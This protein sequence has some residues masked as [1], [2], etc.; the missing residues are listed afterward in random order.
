MTIGDLNLG[1]Y[2][3]AL[4]KELSWEQRLK[5]ASRLGFTFVELSIDETDHRLARLDWSAEQ[6][7]QFRE[8]VLASG[9]TVPTMCF[10]GHRRFPF[11]SH[12]PD[13][14]IKARDLMIKALRFAADTGIRTIQLAGYDVYYEES[15]AQTRQWFKEGL[16]YAVTNAA[17]AQIMIA[18]EI[19]DTPFINSVT[20]FL[21]YKEEL[22]TPWFSVYP[23]IG[24]LSAWGN[25]IEKELEKGIEYA[26]AI[27]LKDTLQV[28]D[29][30]EGKFKEV[31]FGT[32][33]VDFP[34]FFA[35]LKRLSYSG[36]FLIEMW[37]ETSKDPEGDIAHARSWIIEQ[38]RSGGYID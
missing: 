15:D 4:P 28:T 12:D 9:L 23:D 8:I 1:I 26:A 13:I 10:S 25:P 22:K 3:K 27:H 37:T 30:F 21:R 6:R 33:C 16:A 36:T 29:E 18:V 31:P 14:R 5:T 24:N 32:G 7:R 38:M 19:M 2:E 35:L 11:G 20:E 17:K 34:A